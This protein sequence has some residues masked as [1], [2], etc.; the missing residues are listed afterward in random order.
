MNNLIK[1]YKLI[2]N[3]DGSFDCDG[4]VIVYEDLID[5]GKLIIK[6]N[7]V[8]GDFFSTNNKLTSLHGAPKEVGGTFYCDFNP[9]LIISSM[10]KSFETFIC[11]Y[12]NL[13]PN[14]KSTKYVFIHHE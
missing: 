1:K 10:P 3:P 12:N 11:Q 9:D 7:I 2:Q 5:N 8:N 4:T 6:F 13:N 14:S